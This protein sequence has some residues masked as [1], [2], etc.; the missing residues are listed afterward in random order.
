MNELKIKPD[1]YSH[2]LNTDFGKCLD[3]MELEL[4]FMHGKMLTFTAGE[5]IVKQGKYSNGIYILTH[6]TVISLARILGEGTTILE[7]LETGSYFGE[8]SFIESVPCATSLIAKS[9]VECLFISKSYFDVLANT[10]RA[11]RYK[12]LTS[13]IKQTSLRIRKIHDKVIKFMSSSDMITH[14]IISNIIQSMN[15]PT[16]I[17]FDQARVD[18]KKL[19][20]TQYLSAFS[21]EELNELLQHGVLL[22]AAKNCQL[23]HKNEKNPLCFL[24]LHGAVQ[25]SIAHENK[26]AKLSVI[27]PNILFSNNAFID[28]TSEY[29]VTFTTCETT[30]LL[31]LSESCIDSFK[32][33]NPH[34]WSK[35][36]YL[37]FRSLIALEKSIDKLD[38]R[39][40]IETYNR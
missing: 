9:E 4:L 10:F 6:G 38:I 18:I 22:K 2:F 40:N 31:K 23:I 13:I 16:E 19:Q 21:T 35:I 3:E 11:T 29:T 28:K 8:I 30:V 12:L 33:D 32:K 34:L 37:I 14:S 7:T 17:T 1:F 5:T 36:F 27:G 39:L 25:S 20:Q 15:N 24:V 26:V